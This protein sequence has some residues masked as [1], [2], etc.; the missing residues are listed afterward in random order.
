[1]HQDFWLIRYNHTAQARKVIDCFFI[2]KVCY[3]FL[4]VL[5]SYNLLQ[6]QPKRY[7]PVVA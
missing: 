4:P 1:M 3:M 7:L 5:P 2:V 6:E